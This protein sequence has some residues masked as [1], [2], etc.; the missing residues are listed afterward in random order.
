LGRPVRAPLLELPSSATDA[1]LLLPYCIATGNVL[2]YTITATNIG[3]LKLS[4]VSFSIP[5]VSDLACTYGPSNVVLDSSVVLQLDAVVTCTGTYTFTQDDIENP[6][7]V[8][9]ARAAS[10]TVKGALISGSNDVTVVPLNAPAMSVDIKTAD[11]VKPSRAREHC[12]ADTGPASPAQRAAGNGCNCHKGDSVALS[13]PQQPLA[14][15]DPQQSEAIDEH[16]LA[17]LQRTHC[18]VSTCE[19]SQTLPLP[20]WCVLLSCS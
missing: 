5:T 8:V 14:L 1:W 2:T 20:C 13:D 18:C 15:S 6:P 4:N 12:R 3:T 19:C 9:A 7:K 10:T 16:D 11:C 17:C